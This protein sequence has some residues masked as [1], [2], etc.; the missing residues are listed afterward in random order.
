MKC[1]QVDWSVTQFPNSSVFFD[2]NLSGVVASFNVSSA[3]VANIDD[4]LQA[5]ILDY[6]T[7]NT[8]VYNDYF[9]MEMNSSSIEVLDDNFSKVEMNIGFYAKNITNSSLWIEAGKTTSELLFC[10]R[11]DLTANQISTEGA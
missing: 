10:L 7:C 5:L 1:D 6:E 2:D 4:T 3:R 8:T 11:T 9:F